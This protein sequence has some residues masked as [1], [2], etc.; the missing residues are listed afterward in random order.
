MGQ[1]PRHVETWQL[2]ETITHKAGGKTAA[3]LDESGGPICF[4]TGILRAPFDASGYNDPDATRVSLCLEADA[5]LSGWLLELDAEL[6]KLCKVNS[7]KLF[8]KQVYL[9]SE[10]KPNYYS[11]LKSNEKYGSTTLFK[12]KMNKVGKGAVRVWNKAGLSR[13]MPESWAGLQ[14]QARVVI[15]SIWLQSR[16]WGLTFEIADAQ[17]CSEAEPATCPF[18]AQEA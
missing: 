16:S 5:E 13:E 17:I 15:K 7:Q 3:I 12:M 8:G 1:F 9:E 18:P 4:T 14:I 10:L 11:A 6:L 2:C